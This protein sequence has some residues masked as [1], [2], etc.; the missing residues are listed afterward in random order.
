MAVI[1]LV[2]NRT[3]L[4]IH[5]PANPV[6]DA[7]RLRRVVLLGVRGAKVRA[8]LG[9]GVSLLHILGR[10][11]VLIGPA[12]NL[13]HCGAVAFLR[14]VGCPFPERLRALLP[15]G[16]ALTLDCLVQFRPLGRCI[17]CGH[18]VKRLFLLGR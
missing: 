1:H 5:C 7:A 17:E 11:L 13:P 18:A 10:S 12:A 8:A 4:A 3:R 9:L 16:F 14:P 6:G 2:I 15:E